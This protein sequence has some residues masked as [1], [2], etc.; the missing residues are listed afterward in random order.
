[1]LVNSVIWP[2]A[3]SLIQGCPMSCRRQAQGLPPQ[4]TGSFWGT[5]MSL[6]ITLTERGLLPDGI[7]I[8]CFLFA[9]HCS[10]S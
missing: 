10:E 7:L 8:K 9:A 4:C 1:M 5:K 6:G 2:L 3:F